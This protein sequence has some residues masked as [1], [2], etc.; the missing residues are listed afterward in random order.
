[1]YIYTIE[2]YSVIRNEIMLHTKTRMDLGN[3]M[4]SETNQT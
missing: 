4:L 3:I 1:M 2:Y